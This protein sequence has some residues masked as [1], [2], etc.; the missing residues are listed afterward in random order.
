VTLSGHRSNH[1]LGD[2]ERLVAHPFA[3]RRQSGN[4]ILDGNAK[5]EFYKTD[6][7]TGR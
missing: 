4:R 3:V 1:F 7:Q 5:R 2:L 6:D